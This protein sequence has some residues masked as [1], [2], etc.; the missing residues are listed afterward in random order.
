[1]TRLKVFLTFALLCVVIQGGWAWTGSGTEAAPYQISSEEDW[2][3]LCT[4]VNNGTSTYS[5][6]FFKLMDDIVVEETFS[7]P[8]TKMVGISENVNF[9][10]TFD[11]NGHTMTVNYVDNNDEDYSAPFRYIRNATIKNLQVAG[12]ITK[13]KKKN[14]GGLVGVAFGT[15]HI[16]SCRSSVEI[17]FNVGDDCSSGGFIGELGTSSDADDTYFDN[18]LFD[19]KLTGSTSYSWGGFVGWVE[20]EPDVYFNN[21]L[22]N[23]AQMNITSTGCK[24]FARGGSDDI[25]VN[26]CYYKDILGEDQDAIKASNMNNEALRMRLGDAWENIGGQV[27]PI[28][29]LHSFTKGNGT[30]ASPYVIASIDDWNK[31][32]SNVYL[33]VG[34][35]DAYFQMTRD[36]SVSRMVGYHPEGDVF[37]AFQGTFDGGGH[38]LTVNYTTDAEFCGPF[39]YTY[40]ATI[41]NLSTTGTITTSGTNAGGVVGRNG[42]ATLTLTNVTSSVAL[43]STHKGKTQIGGLVG[44]AIQAHFTGCS[45]TGSMKGANSTHCGGLLGY[46]TYESDQSRKAVFVDCFF[47]PSIVTVGGTG[48]CTFANNSTDGVVEITNCYYSLPLGTAQGKKAHSITAG[49][50]VT[51][52]NVGDSIEYDINGILFYNAGFKFDDIL[53][54]GSGDVVS[55]NLNCPWMGE[56][57]F[58]GFQASAGTLTGNDNLYTL[59]MPDDDVVVSTSID[60]S[61]WEGDGTVDSPYII[62]Y[63]T[64]WYLLAQHVAEGTDYS[65][66]Y[67]R[68]AKDITV[69]TMVGTDELHCFSG[70]FDGDGHMLTLD[71]NTFEPYAA[72]FRFVNDA[73][74]HDLTI[75]GSI[76]TS[77]QFAAGF[78]GKAMGTVALNNCRSSVTISS[79]VNGDGTN[80]GFVAI[81]QSGVTSISGCLFDG[82]LLGMATDNNGGFVGWAEDDSVESLLIENSI[83][84]PA[85]VTM[86]GDKTFVRF[87]NG[88]HPTFRN[89]FYTEAFGGAQGKRIYKTEE[90]VAASGLYYALTLF[91]KTYYGKVVINMRV[92]FDETGEEIKPV[93]I[94]MTEDGILIPQE[95]NYTLAWSGDGKEAG[96]YT[97]TITAAANAQLPIP[98]ALFTGSK[99]L[100]YTVVSMNAP[101]DLTATTTYNTATIGWTGSFE[102]YKVRYKPSNLYTAYFTSF[103]DG[104]PEDWTTIDADGDGKCWYAMD[105]LEDFAHSGA[106]FMTSD[107]YDNDNGDLN[108]DN[109]LV[110]PLLP[111]DGLLKVWM[112]GQD[113]NDYREHF[114]IYVSTKGNAATDF[115]DT[116]IVLP[117]TIVTNEYVEYSVNLSKFAGNQGYIAI[118]HFNCAGQFRLNVDDFGLYNVDSSGEEWQEV[119]VTETTA[120]ITGLDPETYYAYQVVGIDADGNHASCIAFLQTEEDVPQVANVS[121]TPG[122]TSAK[123]SWNG[124]GDRYNVR[125][126]YDMS[127]NNTAWVT[128]K[129]DDLWSDSSGYQMLLD[130]DANTFGSV[131]PYNGPL[132]NSGSVSPEVYGEFEYKIPENADG[133]VNTG[134]IVFNESVTIEIPAGTYDWCIPNPT[135]EYNVVYIASFHGNIGGRKDDYTFEPGMSYV[136]SVSLEGDY[137]RVDV[138]VSPKYGDWTQV[139]VENGALNTLLTGLTKNTSYVVQ[140]QAVLDNGKTSEW[141]TIEKFTTLGDGEMVLYDDIDNQEIIDEHDGDTVNVT[142]N[143]RT[144]YKDGTWN[145]LCLPFNTD[146]TGELAEATLMELDTENSGYE[147]ETGFENGT[148]YLNFKPANTIEAGKSYIIKWADTNEVIE[149]PVFEGVT[150]VGGE[151]GSVTSTDN[152]E[153]TGNVAFVGTY[154]PAEIFTTEK[155][156]LYLGDNGKLY[157]PWGDDMTS[158]KVNAFRA[159]FQLNNGLVCGEPEQ[160]GSINAFVLNF[161]GEATGI[162]DADFK[163]AS[164][165]PGISNALGQTWYSI[166]GRR[167]NGKPV[168]KGV[169]IN[170][171]RKIVVK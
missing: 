129:A 121:V 4:N 136:F 55:L 29:N 48:S 77:E 17:I 90:E 11:G 148:L 110:S 155:T 10:G 26:N 16:S 60:E 31:L 19:G 64:Q 140:V 162:V 117:E 94:L 128:L 50:Y 123:V 141:C 36:I 22:F 114:A 101:K 147:H 138:E 86:I 71:Y 134:N 106:A 150:I 161:G 158:F 130:A 25:H 88:N 99:T 2:I 24:T 41:K 51:L 113:L 107:S 127:I 132:S 35:S 104:L 89:S 63:T 126:G 53:Y 98:N 119:E 74:I 139:E 157:Y 47:S 115:T 18:C 6:T 73:T 100:D 1:M 46:K 80:G 146:L 78:I 81:I 149:N 52:E 137:D 49:E 151:P 61:L 7:G 28:V 97:V 44:Y 96:I 3:T 122:M 109:W 112:K 79:T 143:G 43:N 168:S 32:A 153:E 82:S 76:N 102:R 159:Y 84:A 33:G 5:S 124:H 163:S 156:Y 85:E 164:Q 40:G 45:F 165:E 66:K 160:E 68:L 93:P 144:L 111:L 54:A 37:N 83:F 91:D 70:N 103:E 39:C 145:T 125:Y 171:G 38:T 67:F 65:G 20:D 131:I 152:G 57:G 170:N 120:V 108:P 8:P 72:P 166:D 167:L 15:C 95:G 142:L 14:A 34:Y 154:S 69:T 87:N 27:L 42:T 105:K 30:E 12:S 21:C 169:Y 133:D 75:N 23:P 13:T 9:R 59:T 118:R 116:D 135:P 58:N 56:S 92:T 62:R